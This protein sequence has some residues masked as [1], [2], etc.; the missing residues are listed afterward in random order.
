MTK[1]AGKAAAL[2]AQPAKARV[3]AG[4]EPVSTTF[5]LNAPGGSPL[6]LIPL[7]AD[8]SPAGPVAGKVGEAG[9]ESDPGLALFAACAP[10]DRELLLRLIEG[11]R[12]L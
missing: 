4:D 1:K 2:A 5:S 11:V 10:L 8:G 6:G 9:A 7:A 12:L 3:A